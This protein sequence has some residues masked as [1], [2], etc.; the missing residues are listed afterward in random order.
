MG[1]S[2]RLARDERISSPLM[3]QAILAP[4]PPAVRALLAE[5]G[6]TADDPRLEV[7]PG[8]EML[9]FLRDVHG[10]D[11]E[12]A[13]GRYFL[14]GASI[15][16]VLL[17]VLRWRFGDAA[18]VPSLLDFASGY[19]RVTRFLLDAVPASAII[20]VDL[21]PAARAFQQRVLGVRALASSAAPESLALPGRYAAILVT[22]L[23]THL[24]EAR[25]A[26]W[27]HALLGRLEPGGLLVFS[28][29]DL[30]LLPAEQRPSAGCC[31]QPVSEIAALA[32][33]DYGSTW[34]DEP[35]VRAALAASGAPGSAIRLP[36]AL[37]GYQDLWVVVPEPGETFASL[38]LQT[39]PEVVVEAC[40]V[41]GGEL[42][43]RGWAHGRYGGISRIEVALDGAL[44]GSAPVDGE[45]DDV[46][47]VLGPTARRC[48]WIVR[49]PFPAAASPVDS[50]LLLRAV[51]A[52]GARHVVWAGRPV[53]AA[54][55][56][57]GLQA[58]EAEA[59]LH[60][61]R[62]ERAAERAAT[63]Q[64]IAD[65]RATVARMRA[66]GFWKLRDAWFAIKRALRLT[67]EA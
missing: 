12:H 26:P 34:V 45:R 2:T 5:W 30:S 50:V 56:A 7:D 46:A 17:Q 15:A 48:G 35:F 42:T 57:R 33:E 64:E 8:D 63:G 31:F 21:L 18:A 53:T 60:N 38:S 51:D 11:G 3:P 14:S 19:G 59:A 24:P 22:S 66:S 9:G 41:T 61:V 62:C 28:T 16:R 55:A 54:L 39:E 32:E 4:A 37:C 13:L 20:A 29:H 67:D 49:S 6:R 58:R 65:L 1:G 43:L 23:F 25:F 27:L 47:A 10:G 44:V 52:R 36:R 40:D